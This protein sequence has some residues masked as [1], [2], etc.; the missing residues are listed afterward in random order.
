METVDGDNDA[1]NAAAR[2]RRG[3]FRHLV[4]TQEGRVIGIIA[5][6]DIAALVGD[7]VAP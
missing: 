6:R 7:D 4:V 2:M 3:H 5:M 1:R